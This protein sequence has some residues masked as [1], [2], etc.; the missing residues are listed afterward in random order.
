LKQS[1]P[2]VQVEQDAASGPHASRRNTQAPLASQVPPVSQALIPSSH[3]PFVLVG[4]AWQVP[5]EQTPAAQS[6]LRPVQFKGVPTQTPAEHA[7]VVQALSSVQA[8][9]LSSLC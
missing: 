2:L 5:L 9:V 6:V 4:C 8:A 1:G 7:S 3:V